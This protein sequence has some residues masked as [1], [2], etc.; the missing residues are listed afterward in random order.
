M[1]SFSMWLVDTGRIKDGCS[2]GELWDIWN[3][4]GACNEFPSDFYAYV[5]V[6]NW[7]DND[8]YLF[9]PGFHFFLAWLDHDAW[10]Q[11]LAIKRITS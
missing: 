11:W 10:L 6:P 1:Q 3:N 8:P 4:R 5:K 7:V 2:L 9:F